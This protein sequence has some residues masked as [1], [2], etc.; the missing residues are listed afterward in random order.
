MVTKFEAV[1]LDQ[2]SFIFVHLISASLILR[3][4]RSGTDLILIW[5]KAIYRMR[6]GLCKQCR[7]HLWCQAE[8]L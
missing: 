5:H 1:L 7:H 3:C 2:T 6:R 8:I 4:Y